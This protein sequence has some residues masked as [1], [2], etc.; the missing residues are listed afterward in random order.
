[1]TNHISRNLGP[2]ISTKKK[3]KKLAHADR[4]N[5]ILYLKNTLKIAAS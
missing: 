5:S 3:K 4:D 1:M 2:I